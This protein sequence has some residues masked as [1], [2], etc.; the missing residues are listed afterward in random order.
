MLMLVLGTHAKNAYTQLILLM[1]ILSHNMTTMTDLW[2]FKMRFFLLSSKDWKIHFSSASL[3]FNRFTYNKERI[4]KKHVHSLHC[5]REKW[6]KKRLQ[7]EKMVILNV[8]K[9]NIK[10]L[11]VTHQIDNSFKLKSIKFSFSANKQ[12]TARSFFVCVCVWKED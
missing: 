4:N 9:S 5:K 10:T 7:L 12:K 8:I 3:I 11:F 1:L 2:I 6:E